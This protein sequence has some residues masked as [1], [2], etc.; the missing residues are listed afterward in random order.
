MTGVEIVVSPNEVLAMTAKCWMLEEAGNKFVVFDLVDSFLLEGSL[1][2]PGPEQLPGIPA[3][4]LVGLASFFSHLVLH[5][6]GQFSW[7]CIF[8]ISETR[9]NNYTGARSGDEYKL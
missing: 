6:S 8:Y 7:C 9:C 1:P 4:H 5:R 3:L 2:G